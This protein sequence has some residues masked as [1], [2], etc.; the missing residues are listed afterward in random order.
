MGAT[1]QIIAGD[2]DRSLNAVD[3]LGLQWTTHTQR[4]AVRGATPE[5]LA[6]AFLVS[7]RSLAI[8]MRQLAAAKLYWDQAR[9]YLLLGKGR[10]L[11]GHTAWP[12]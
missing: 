2:F 3:V 5:Q 9:K 4:A 6:I 1:Y 7:K 8:R 10:V 12:M 11:P